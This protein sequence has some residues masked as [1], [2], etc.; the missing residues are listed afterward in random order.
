MKTINNNHVLI[1][2]LC[3]GK[4]TRLYNTIGHGCKAAAIIN[5]EPWIKTA[6][7]ILKTV[8]NSE[9][10]LN[11][12]SEHF[13]L[14]KGI[15]ISDCDH[16]YVEAERNGFGKVI[17]DIC[18]EYTGFKEY[19]FLLGDI[20]FTADFVPY[21]KQAISLCNKKN[22]ITL[23]RPPRSSLY[24]YDVIDFQDGLPAVKKANGPNG[25]QV[26]GCIIISSHSI[27]S[28]LNQINQPNISFS[29]LHNIL[30]KNGANVLPISI[31]VQFEDFGTPERFRVSR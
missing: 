3:G 24:D 17:S 12:N 26:G 16:I 21:L 25:M 29:A 18:Q 2:L 7:R 27:C 9:L 30:I 5:G 4:G 11:I 10:L 15:D 8:E 13:N 1:S 14:I 19:V 23:V 31:P 22:F 20:L 6:I 28:N